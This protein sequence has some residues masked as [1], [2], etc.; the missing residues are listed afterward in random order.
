MKFFVVYISPAGTTRHVAQVIRDELSAHNRQS[1]ILD[2]GDRK[3]IADINNLQTAVAQEACLFIGSPVYACHAVPAVMNFITTLNT[4]SGCCCVPF[5]TW[6]AVT[7]GLALSEMSLLLEAKGY[8]V[9]GAAKIIAEHSLLWSAH[10]PLGKGR[11]NADDDRSIR[12]MV[13]N[14]VAAADA[15]TI[16]FLPAAALNYQPEFLQKTMASLSLAAVKKVLPQISVAG[17]LCTRCGACVAACPADAIRLAPLPE[18]RS[19]CIACYNCLR[20]CPEHALQ[21]DFSQMEAGL[22]K[23]AE[24]FGER[25]ETVVYLT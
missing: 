16:K 21:A 23:R 3:C 19:A 1:V 5:V 25:K 10:N 17:E 4:G 9:A 12:A 11:P 14:I 13:Q 8:P 22:N 15:G 24:D 7:S 2:L 18:F 6:G 20:A